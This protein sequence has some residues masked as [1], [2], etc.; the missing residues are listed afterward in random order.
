[1]KNVY[2]RFSW[3]LATACIFIS[4]AHADTSPK[5]IA[6]QKWHMA[7]S[8]NFTVMSDAGEKRAIKLAQ[9]LERFRLVFSLLTNVDLENS[10]RPVSLIATKRDNTYQ[11][12]TGN[13]KNM[14]NTAGF[15]MDTTNGNYSA[16][17]LSKGNDK[18]N[19]SIL[20]HEYTHYAKANLVSA[21]SPYW[22]SEGFADFM[23]QIEFENDSVVNFGKPHVRHLQNISV[24]K[25]MPLE[26]LLSATHIDSAKRDERYKIYSQGWLLVHYFSQD[27]E[28]SKQKKKYFDLLAQGLSP[29]EAIEQSTG[30]SLSD[31]EKTLR[32]H[33]K[34]RRHSYSQITLKS[35][36]QDSDIQVR[37]LS[38]AEAVYEIGVFALQTSLGY[39][40]SRPFFEKALKL[41]PDY[42][43]AL[44]GLANTYLSSDSGKMTEL[45]NR[46]K[47]IEP[48]NPWTATISGHLNGWKMDEHDD[49]KSQKKYWNLAVKD[50]NLAIKIDDANLEAILAAA[51][52]YAKK[53]R[54]EKYL[55]LIEYAYI[56]APSNYQIR[57]RLIYGYLQSKQVEK[58]DSIANLIRRNHHMS[59]SNIKRFEDWYAKSKSDACDNDEEILSE[60]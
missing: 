12:L 16:I 27:S 56:V 55:E 24:M 42:A 2:L 21:N 5:K 37:R 39:S 49:E 10:M 59:E 6:K 26:T 60:C 33:A 41:K 43:N 51:D 20:F 48:K 46:S 50:Y 8:P 30:M 14:R 52:L 1:M 23:G 22:Y 28:R 7:K 25:W 9:N 57:T 40:T 34:Q 44:T 19:L 18:F 31:F 58:A 54:N 15:F 32:K 36:F 35:P 11:F 4:L 13:S 29:R 3:A 45:I 53:N 17:K 47:E 38:D